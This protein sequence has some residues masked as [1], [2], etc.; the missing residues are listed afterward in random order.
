[1]KADPAK[2]IKKYATYQPSEI[3]TV[4][5]F[6]IP[7]IQASQRIHLKV[8]SSKDIFLIPIVCYIFPGQI[9]TSSISDSK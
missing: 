6:D 7:K 1:M 5:T 9:F 8:T 2:D 4:S 3:F